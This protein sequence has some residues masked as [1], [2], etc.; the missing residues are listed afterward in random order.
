MPKWQSV[1]INLM[2][3]AMVIGAFTSIPWFIGPQLPMLNRLV[4]QGWATVFVLGWIA[5]LF[6]PVPPSGVGFNAWPFS[7]PFVVW[8]GIVL[9]SGGFWL[10]MPHASESVVLACIVCQVC[11]VTVYIM[12]TIQPPPSRGRLPLAPLALPVSIGLY[13]MVHPTRYSAAL[14]IFD[15]SYAV[16]I[17]MLQRFVQ[18]AVDEAWAARRAAETALVQVAAERDA[19]TRFLESAS[20]DL[21]QPL[22]AA[23]L[24][25][26]QVLRSPTTAARQTAARRVT[27][28]FDATEQLLRRMLE[29]LRLE[30]GAVEARVERVAVGPLIARVVE[31]NEP[32]ARLAR[33]EITPMTSRL[34]A[35]ADP[36]LL[37]RTLGNLIVNALRHAKAGRVLVGARRCDGRIRL[38]VLDDGVGIPAADAPR[39]FDDYVQGS[40]HGDEVR[41][42]FGLGLA[43]ARRMTRL[44]GGE[45]A[46][47]ASWRNGSAF[48][49]ELPA[50]PDKAG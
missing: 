26:D 14:V 27:W 2:A 40:N 44:M 25:F 30:S 28:A 35:L 11:T 9:L 10:W 29:H 21:G 16:T 22:Q 47:E 19:K 41:G 32:A 45:V 18:N 37:E 20:H 49:I 36:G 33:V 42:G 7:S 1:I 24:F 3:V 17:M 46:Y 8:G 6:R 15:V 23:R 38:W 31:M 39:L 4:V 48:W 34:E 50:A 12:T 5:M 43:S 13:L